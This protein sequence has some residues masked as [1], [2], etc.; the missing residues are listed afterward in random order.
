M[1]SALSGFVPTT[2]SPIA[3]SSAPFAS[4][5]SFSPS[6][7]S[8]PFPSLP[9]F[10]PTTPSPIVSSYPNYSPTT[11]SPIASAYPNYS[12]TTPAPIGS[13]PIP[14]PSS[15]FLPSNQPIYQVPSSTQAPYRPNNYVPPPNRPSFPDYHAPTPFPGYHYTN[16]RINDQYSRVNHQQT[17]APVF[18]SPSTQRPYSFSTVAAPSTIDSRSTTLAPPLINNFNSITSTTPTPFDDDERRVQF[19]QYVPPTPIVASTPRPFE[20]VSPDNTILITPKP[21]FYG[22]GDQ[23][24]R[25]NQRLPNSLSINQDLLP[26]FLTVGPLNAARSQNFISDPNSP[27]PSRVGPLTVTNFN[28]RKK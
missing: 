11:P 5:P 23:Q 10:S 24:I 16:P 8:T 26:P 19:K 13:S 28:Y 6:G 2:Q 20:S 15:A 25:G 12:P 17:P 9:S 1:S 18:F 3:S 22:G 4:F 27:L 21:Y 14:F 7:S